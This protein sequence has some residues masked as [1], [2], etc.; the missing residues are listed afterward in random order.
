MRIGKNP[1]LVHSSASALS[2]KGVFTGQG[3]SSKVSTISLSTRKSSCLK[4]AKPKPGPPVVSISTT[5][6]TPIASGFAQAVFGCGGTGGL[7]GITAVTST[8]S[9]L[10]IG[11]AEAAAASRSAGWALTVAAT[12]KSAR[13]EDVQNHTAPITTPAPRLAIIRPNALP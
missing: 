6:L 8:S 1:A 3:P 10:G 2:T 9:A 5:R 11:L 12:A 13:G 4:C 7:A